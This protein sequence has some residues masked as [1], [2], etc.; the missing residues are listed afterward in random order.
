MHSPL[1]KA[2]QAICSSRNASGKLPWRVKL[3]CQ[4]VKSPSAPSASDILSTTSRIAVAWLNVEEGNPNQNV[5]S[6]DSAHTCV[7]YPQHR[8]HRKADVQEI[9]QLPKLYNQYAW[10]LG[11]W[12]MC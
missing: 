10:T 3:R 9:P 8:S 4:S 7:G 5:G 11:G 12:C 2:V 6:D 1:G